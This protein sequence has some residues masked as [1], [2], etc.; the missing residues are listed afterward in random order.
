MYVYTIVLGIKV[1]SLSYVSAYV[2]IVEINLSWIFIFNR[3]L[4]TKTFFDS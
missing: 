2:E 3:K 4:Q 1:N